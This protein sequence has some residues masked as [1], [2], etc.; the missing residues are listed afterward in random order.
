MNGVGV[1]LGPNYKSHTVMNL[2]LQKKEGNLFFFGVYQL[3]DESIELI[4]Q[5]LIG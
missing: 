1:V 5:L 2:E 3:M 4:R